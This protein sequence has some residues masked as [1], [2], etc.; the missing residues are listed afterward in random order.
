MKLMAFIFCS[1]SSTISN[2]AKKMI[3]IMLQPDPQKRPNI[4]QLLKDEFF[5]SG[6]MP[7]SL[8]ASCLTMAPRFDQIDK[9]HRAPLLQ[10]NGKK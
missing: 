2:P 7:T 3:M 8:P 5:Y 1:V 6:Y 4:H 10:I 9:A